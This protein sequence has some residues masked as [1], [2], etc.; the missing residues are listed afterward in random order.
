MMT[1]Y[2]AGATIVFS[3]PV[4]LAILAKRDHK[5]M[6][7]GVMSG[8]LTIPVG[9][10]LAML[11]VMWSGARIRSEASPTGP[12]DTPVEGLTIGALVGNMIPLIIV[13]AVIAAGL[14]FLPDLM[15]KLF[16]WFGRFVDA[17]AKLLLAISI[18]EYFTGIFSRIF[19]GWGFGAI[20]ATPDDQFR[21][22]E[23]AGAVGIMLAGAFPM[24]YAIQKYLSQPL[25][26]LGSR[27]GLSETAMA[28]ILGSTANILA[29]FHLIEKMSAK[30]KVMTIAFATT[31]AFLLGDHLSFT[32]NFQPNLIAA[33]LLGKIV[34]AVCAM[35]IARF[36]AVPTAIRHEE[37]QAKADGLSETGARHHHD[38]EQESARAS[39]PRWLERDDVIEEPR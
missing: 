39:A 22:L 13:I 1:G 23:V 18:V 2:M 14:K 17:A 30:D 33:V 7:L 29:L 11:T 15:I 24:V 6:A 31:G 25:A 8:I 16:M 28:G 34:A 19:G 5:Y 37:A 10:V 3:I 20:I 9:V 32:A 12:A 26:W 35:V 36:I 38:E 21:A 4:G 27:F